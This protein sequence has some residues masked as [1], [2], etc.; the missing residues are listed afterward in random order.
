MSISAVCCR[1]GG[2]VILH[3]GVAA[4]SVASVTAGS[5]VAG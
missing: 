1:G 2:V 4:S 5:F 3:G